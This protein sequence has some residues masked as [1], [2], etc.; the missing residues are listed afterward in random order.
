[1][2]EKQRK[3]FYFPAWN[4]CASANDWRMAKGRLVADLDNQAA[5][6]ERWPELAYGLYLR[7]TQAA[8][9]RAEQL[10]R[11][12]TAEDLRHACHIVCFGRDKSS[13]DLSNHEVNRVVVLFRLL[14]EPEDLD[15]VMDWLNPD[16]ADKRAL[17]QFLK[18]L[19]PEGTLCA[20][21]RN[22]YHTIYWED[23]DVQQIRWILKQVKN[24][25]AETARPMAAEHG[26]RERDPEMEPF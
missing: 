11:G 10:H 13:E 15:A 12:V 2:T 16:Q 6:C 9:I 23:L 17:V 14:S 21:S 3:F 7:V 19:A 18:K 24:R 25:K 20:I 8:F 4:R 5:D 22:A 26:T 1:M